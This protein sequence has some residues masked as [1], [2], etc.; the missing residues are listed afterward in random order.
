MSNG[1]SVWLNVN[2]L[3]F[4][5]SDHF[6]RTSPLR[7]RYHR[8]AHPLRFSM[9]SFAGGSKSLP[10]DDHPSFTPGCRPR[11]LEPL[12]RPGKRRRSV[13]PMNDKLSRH[14]KRPSYL[15]P[16]LQAALPKIRKEEYW[17]TQSPQPSP[18]IT[19]AV[20]SMNERTTRLGLE[21]AYPEDV[22]MD[23]CPHSDGE[24]VEEDATNYERVPMHHPTPNLASSIL[25]LHK[26]HPIAYQQHLALISSSRSKKLLNSNNRQPNPTHPKHS[27]D[28]D[29][30]ASSKKEN[31][32]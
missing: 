23:C 16:H 1:A 15:Q 3:S 24:D 8:Q 27:L 28:Q 5:G 18:T 4:F 19:A 11:P 29:H 2:K 31:N 30:R 7:S 17:A 12:D 6:E 13:S 26:P 14:N 25:P 20:D 10:Q 32:S 21:N 9:D 22:E